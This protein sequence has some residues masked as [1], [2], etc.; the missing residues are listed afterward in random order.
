MN[1]L[2]PTLMKITMSGTMFNEI[3][4]G[5]PDLFNK[6]KTISGPGFLICLTLITACSEEEI[7]TVKGRDQTI[8]MKAYKECRE[9]PKYLIFPK[10]HYVFTMKGVRFPIRII[11]LKNGRV[12]YERIHY[13]GEHP[14]ILP[15]PDL[16]I[17]T[18]ICK[19]RGDSR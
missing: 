13:P 2:T 19:E 15:K 1:V 16:V 12:V 9:A 3:S 10:P 11:G 4:P 8:G 17:E 5:T 18:P 14:I 6:C 7:K